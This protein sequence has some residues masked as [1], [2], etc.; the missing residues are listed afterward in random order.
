M[1]TANLERGRTLVPGYGAY[2]AQKGMYWNTRRRYVS[3]GYFEA[4]NLVK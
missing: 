2:P 4:A 1:K 3:M